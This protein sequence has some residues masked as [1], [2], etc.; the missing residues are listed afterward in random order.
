MS[1]QAL[2]WLAFDVTV[3]GFVIWVIYV[4]ARFVCMG[5]FQLHTLATDELVALYERQRVQEEEELEELRLRKEEERQRQLEEAEERRRRR[6]LEI[7]VELRAEE[8]AI[9]REG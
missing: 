1:L 5:I 9:M 8:A 7:E 3:A 6:E 2:S 4:P